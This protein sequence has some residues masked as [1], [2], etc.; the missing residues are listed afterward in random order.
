MWQSL[1]SPDW[2]GT[3]GTVFMGGMNFMNYAINP[4]AST[5][6]YVLNSFNG[7]QSQ[8][9]SIRSW[10]EASP[11][12][13]LLAL[14]DDRTSTMLSYLNMTG[15]TGSGGTGNNVV[16]TNF[17]RTINTG[18]TYTMDNNELYDYLFRSGPFTKDGDPIQKDQIKLLPYDASNNCLTAWPETMI[19]LM[20]DEN[21]KSR[22]ILG[23][24]PT[25]RIIYTGEMDL[26][27]TMG[28]SSIAYTENGITYTGTSNYYA[29]PYSEYNLKFLNN[30]IAWMMNVVMY[31]DEFTGKFI[32]G[33]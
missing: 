17:A 11:N 24:D 14:S 12:R 26:F 31:G 8:G 21:D 28:V 1:N 5:D 23:V 29:G 16:K 6:I 18:D 20:L 10:L 33:N 30:L 9:N 32:V 13:V 25:L 19:P 27:G 7:D 2:F 3:N 15:Y 4:D 22:L